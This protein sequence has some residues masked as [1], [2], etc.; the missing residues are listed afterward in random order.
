MGASLRARAPKAVA[1][2][3]A[4][5]TQAVATGVKSMSAKQME[6]M[7]KKGGSAAVSTEKPEYM[8]LDRLLDTYDFKFNVGDKVRG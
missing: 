6:A 1:P 7:W 8:E 2:R 3:S 5:T 4:V